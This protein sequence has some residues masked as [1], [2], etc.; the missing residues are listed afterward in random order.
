MYYIEVRYGFIWQYQ[1]IVSKELAC[2]DN[3][4]K[5][6]KVADTVF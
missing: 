6:G 2:G 3:C 1:N 5:T 4:R